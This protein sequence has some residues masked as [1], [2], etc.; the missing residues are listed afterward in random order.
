MMNKIW[1]QYSYAIFLIILSCAL[2]LIMSLRVQ[3]MENDEYLSVTVSEGDSLWKISTQFSEQHSLSH[4]EFVN[5]VKQR[6]NIEGDRI[7]PGE[8]IIIPI[9][10]KASQ[11]TELASAA[12]E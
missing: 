10:Q 5:W 1:K 11:L 9:N 12:N 6:N 2:A 7:F 4:K 3:T 8:E